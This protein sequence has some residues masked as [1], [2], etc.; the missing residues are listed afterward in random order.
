MVPERALKRPIIQ[1]MDFIVENSYSL[2]C[3]CC[4]ACCC[5]FFFYFY[6]NQFK[7]F[8]VRLIVSRFDF[9]IK[10]IIKNYKEFNILYHCRRRHLHHFYWTFINGF[11]WAIKWNQIESDRGNLTQTTCCFLKTGYQKCNDNNKQTKLVSNK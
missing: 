7:M 6:N 10:I 4:V 11:L 2:F 5:C 1:Q 8:N 9:G 3:F